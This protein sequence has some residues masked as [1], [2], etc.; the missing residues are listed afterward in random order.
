MCK[1]I[2]RQTTKCFTGLLMSPALPKLEMRIIV[3]ESVKNTLMDSQM[4][5][6]MFPKVSKI[7]KAGIQ[8][9]TGYLRDSVGLVPDHNSKENITIEQVT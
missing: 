3:V 6:H 7:S 1:K 8:A 5:C 2:S 9:R 4:T